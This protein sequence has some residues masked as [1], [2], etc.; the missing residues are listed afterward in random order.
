MEQSARSEL[1]EGIKSAAAKIM[2]GL[3]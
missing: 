3:T 2:S 1:E